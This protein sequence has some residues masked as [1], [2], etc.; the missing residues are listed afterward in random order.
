M[1]EIFAG[2]ACG[3]KTGMIHRHIKEDNDMAYDGFAINEYPDAA[4]ICAQ[5]DE[6]KDEVKKAILNLPGQS[7]EVDMC[8]LQIRQSFSCYDEEVYHIEK[9]YIDPAKGLIRVQLMEY[10]DSI[11][12]SEFSIDD[13][14]G[15]YEELHKNI[16]VPKYGYRIVY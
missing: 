15:I 1:K 4:E 13:Q 10:A 11:E 2:G 3:A 14:F 8:G 12:L 5:L 9:I 7:C 16:S 6:L